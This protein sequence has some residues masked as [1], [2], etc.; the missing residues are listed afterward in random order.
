MGMGQT[1]EMALDVD[2]Q[3][4]GEG[5]EVKREFLR[6]ARENGLRAAIAWRDSRAE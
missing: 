1:L 2:L 6:I 5:T 3:I 4:E